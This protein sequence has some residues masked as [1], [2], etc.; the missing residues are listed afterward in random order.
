MIK[1]RLV[2]SLLYADGFIV[3]SRN[4]RHTNIVG[5]IR[6]SIE[7]FNV[8]EA[9]EI[10]ILN[11]SR[12]R[13]SFDTFV[14]HIKEVSKISFL[15]LSIGGW[16]DSKEKAESL[17]NN[18]ADKVIVNTVAFD[19]P[20]VVNDIAKSFGEQS[21]VVSIDVRKIDGIHMVYVDRGLK[22]IKCDV[23][24]W[25]KK[26]E[27]LGVGEI[28]L[29]SIDHDGSKNGY[30][31]ELMKKVSESIEIPVIAFGG[32]QDFHDMSVCLQE[33]NVEAVAAGNPFHYTEQSTRIAKKE[34]INSG[35]DV[36][37]PNNYFNY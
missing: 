19:N 7:F 9:D 1:K 35:I 5:D 36:R 25:A 8:W 14:K 16:I 26:M 32:V 37:V 23:I 24:T 4:F 13:N 29:T 6:I 2:V 34:L 21:I 17:F 3:Q 15:P 20:H 30:D 28:Y 10:V 33:T 12:N 31:L 11:V 22:D 27:E 18:G